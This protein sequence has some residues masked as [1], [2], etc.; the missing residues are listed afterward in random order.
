MAVSIVSSI[1]LIALF[2]AVL[3]GALSR[4][5]SGA[6][7]DA[8]DSN[9]STLAVPSQGQGQDELGTTGD[10]DGSST[11]A[12]GD[13]VVVVPADGKV[14]DTAVGGGDW[15]VAAI[16]NAAT[17]CPFAKNVRDAY[18]TLE[19]AGSSTSVHA[20]SPVTHK[21]Y[22]MDCVGGMPV[23]CTGGKHAVVLIFG[24]DT[25]VEHE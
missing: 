14:C 8:Y 16:G 3:I 21:W 12:A 5:D 6:S 24:S 4:S 25:T 1:A 10:D 15:S 9:A 18:N 19:A 23:R 20:Y 2:W 11:P 13:A 7:S 17:S 22:R